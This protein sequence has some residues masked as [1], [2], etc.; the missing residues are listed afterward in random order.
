MRSESKKNGLFYLTG[1]RFECQGDGKCCVTRGEYG[2]VY[3]SFNDR[4]RLAAHF[5]VSL[6]VFNQKYVIK[7]D[8]WYRLRYEGRDCPFLIR[9]RC[10]VYEAR[11][12]QCRTWPFWS[13]NMNPAVWEEIA[14]YCPGI[15]K[16]RLYSAEEISRILTRKQDISG[17]PD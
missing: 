12:W 2:Y 9:T 14:A 6:S 17:K 5:G 15:G 11:P 1:L 3:L 4:K 13:E 7:E 16:G 10:S 8:G